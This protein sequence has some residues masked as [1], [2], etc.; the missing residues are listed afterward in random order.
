[1]SKPE[2]RETKPAS[3]ITKE[4]RSQ[5][6]ASKPVEEEASGAHFMEDG[7]HLLLSELV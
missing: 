4:I 6:V 1:L 7:R 2:I 3:R 5:A